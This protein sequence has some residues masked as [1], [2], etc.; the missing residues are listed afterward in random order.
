MFFCF[1]LFFAGFFFRFLSKSLN[2]ENAW[3]LL[4][5]FHKGFFSKKYILLYKFRGRK[6]VVFLSSFRKIFLTYHIANSFR[7]L[8]FTIHFRNFTNDF[9][10][11]LL[12]RILNILLYHVFFMKILSIT[13]KRKVQSAKENDQKSYYNPVILRSNIIEN[14]L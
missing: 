9:S 3:F 7:N 8:V 2:M 14:M 11:H 5:N 1:F 13:Q 6:L 10:S 4:E 12:F